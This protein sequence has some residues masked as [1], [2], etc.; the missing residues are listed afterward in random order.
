[1]IFAISSPRPASPR[2][3]RVL[4]VILI[5]AGLFLAFIA[6]AVF[7]SQGSQITVTAKVLSERCHPQYDLATH[8][9]E[10]RCDAGVQFITVSG[11]VVTTSV[12][13]AFPSE[14]HGSGSSKTIDLRYD[15]DDPTEPYKQSN[16]MPLG[17][18]LMLLGVG[19]AVLLWGSWMA[20]RADHIAQRSQERLQ[21]AKV[22]AGR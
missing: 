20:A 21:R 15:S 8:R 10:T 12:G 9:G 6:L 19:C 2:G 14:F 1:M 22:R 17:T 18:F 16:Y 3:I 5:I 7:L 4:A 11:R 13:D